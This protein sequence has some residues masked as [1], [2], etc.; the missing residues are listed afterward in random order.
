LCLPNHFFV[1]AESISY[2]GTVGRDAGD[3][4]ATLE[5][6]RRGELQPTPPA[7]KP[8]KS[9]SAEGSPAAVLHLDSPAREKDAESKPPEEKEGG[10]SGRPPAAVPAR[11]KLLPTPPTTLLRKPPKSASPE[12][13]SAAVLHLDSPAR[14]EERRGG[15][16]P[17]KTG[18]ERES[19]ARSFGLDRYESGA[20]AKDRT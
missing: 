1:F 17:E 12:G 18:T 20:R 16:G 5:G 8:P 11:R 9:A 15:V 10:G 2:S 14:E 19:G 3:G 6:R 7:G 4:E 13:S